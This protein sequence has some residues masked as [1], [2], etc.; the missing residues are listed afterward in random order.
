MD[1]VVERGA[2]VIMVIVGVLVFTNYCLVLNAWAI[3][4][5]PDWLLRRL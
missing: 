5:T 3:V 4:L 2:G 1:P